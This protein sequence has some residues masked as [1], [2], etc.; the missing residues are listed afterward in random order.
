MQ[1]LFQPHYL[2]CQFCKSTVGIYLRKVGINFEF[3]YC[4]NCK[5]KM[6]I[7]LYRYLQENQIHFVKDLFDVTKK[8]SVQR[9]TGEIETD[10][11]ISSPIYGTTLRYTDDNQGEWI[12]LAKGDLNKII[13]LTEFVN[14][15]PKK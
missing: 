2:S 15:N 13:P 6:E 3:L 14:L 4:E 11:E 9:S 8:Y 10:W 5:F 7:D 1:P 12:H